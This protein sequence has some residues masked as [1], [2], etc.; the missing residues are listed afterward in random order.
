[1][2]VFYRC[3]PG[4]SSHSNP[5]GTEKKAIF[6]E[7]LKS[8][9]SA[10]TENKVEIT[11]VSD[12]VPDDWFDIPAL[13]HPKIIHP[14]EHSFTGM[15]SLY[16]SL[17]FTIDEIGKL[18]DNDKVLI[19]EDDYL[20]LPDTLGKLERALDVMPMISPYDHPGHYT[21][22]RF[23]NQPKKMVLFENHTFRSAPSNTHTFAAPAWVFKKHGEMI[24]TMGDHE[25]FT[26]VGIDL[27]VPVP[28]FATHC[29]EG[30]MAPNVKWIE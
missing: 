1:M 30:L 17:S 6:D 3:Y 2:K 25:F 26:K 18:E 28:S 21:E 8:F 22:E 14:P 5:L 27:Y 20:W 9:L 13:F 29:V 12:G 16:S 15:K 10:D 24:K 11:F 19:C 7:C 4:L 23:K